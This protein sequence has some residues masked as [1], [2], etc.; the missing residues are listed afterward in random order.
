MLP[1]DFLGRSAELKELED[2]Y[3]LIANC[4]GPRVAILTAESGV[5]KTRLLVELYSRLVSRQDGDD[6]WPA[7]LPANDVSLPLNPEP[8]Q[9][10]WA[11]DRTSA[12]PFIWWG[13]RG[14][15]PQRRNSTWSDGGAVNSAAIALLPHLYFLEHTRVAN[16]VKWD[17]VDLSVDGALEA[18]GLFADSIPGV[19]LL[20]SLALNR[21]KRWKQA[22]ELLQLQAARSNIHVASELRALR[23]DEQLLDG[24]KALLTSGDTASS[25]SKGVPVVVCIDD[26]HWLDPIS[27]R[28][29]AKLLEAALQANW[30]LL[31]IFTA[32][33][34]PWHAALE[35]AVT[36]EWEELRAAL[37]TLR[38]MS[39]ADQRALEP[40]DCVDQIIRDVYLGLHVDQR[41]MIADKVGADLYRL[42][43][44]LRSLSENNRRFVDRDV[45]KELN[46]EGL[47][48]LR[49]LKRGR[50]EIVRDRFEQLPPEV[51]EF[52]GL[53]SL[54]G[55]ELPE[56][57]GL[58]V[59]GALA[60]SGWPDIG[61]Y[62]A[63]QLLERA[64][65]THFLLVRT[66][67]NVLGFAD[68]AMAEAA[69]ERILTSSEDV[70]KVRLQARV[71][72]ASWMCSAKFET[73]GWTEL[74]VFL[75]TAAWAVHHE[76][77]DGSTDRSLCRTIATSIVTM[78][79]IARMPVPREL[80]DQA[81]PDS[82][83][84]ALETTAFRS[85]LP[86]RWQ[87]K[88]LMRH[89]SDLG[90]RARESTMTYLELRDAA[91][92]NLS[93]AVDALLAKP[94]W[95]LVEAASL[96]AVAG[97]AMAWS[98]I[99][100]FQAADDWQKTLNQLPPDA[101]PP[102]SHAL[103]SEISRLT[104]GDSLTRTLRICLLAQRVDAERDRV[105]D[106]VLPVVNE[107]IALAA[108]GQFLNQ[109]AQLILQGPLA[110]ALLAWPSYGAR[111]D[112]T[113][114][115]ANA[116]V[117][118]FDGCELSTLGSFQLASLALCVPRA[119]A[120]RG[121]LA[122]RYE[123]VMNI[124]MEL[125]RRGMGAV[126]QDWTW[127]GHEAVLLES[128]HIR[129]DG[130]QLPT[131]SLSVDATWSS[132]T[133][134]LQ[135]ICAEEVHLREVDL[136]N[137]C[138]SCLHPLSRLLLEL[139]DIPPSAFSA[140]VLR[141]SALSYSARRPLTI[142]AAKAWMYE[143]QSALD[144]LGSRGAPTNV[145][146][147][148]NLLAATL[149]YSREYQGLFKDWMRDQ[150]VAKLVGRVIR[151]QVPHPNRPRVLTS[152]LSPIA[153]CVEQ[154]PEADRSEVLKSA[155]MV[156][157]FTTMEWEDQPGEQLNALLTDLRDARNSLEGGGKWHTDH[158]PVIR[159]L[160]AKYA[161]VSGSVDGSCG[162]RGAH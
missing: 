41:R 80:L 161:A 52:I 97:V 143:A 129:E 159:R 62:D 119:M 59:I 63:Q 43:E 49:K 111:L 152:C 135:R 9:F 46:S 14:V 90:F 79:Q 114:L 4:H 75:K 22:K 126:V 121:T 20:K 86:A 28:F 151:D 25:D 132:V 138:I 36:P 88:W 47:D 32:W 89:A 100:Q 30:P 133:R 34:E 55:P 113:A 120:W 94:S 146:L 56:A 92:K 27:V 71:V 18:V 103:E 57:M 104:Q 153:D 60:D 82:D 149:L 150:K 93:C 105:D 7:H 118:A 147:A 115:V 69:A 72:V 81:S 45:R 110:Q 12:A 96:S 54:M 11:E 160:I 29:L 50:G 83:T 102:I 66:T 99:N 106:F 108:G 15:D 8:A 40:S 144:R 131:S 162:F 156:L 13:L 3:E 61:G 134:K 21:W 31:L 98:A 155:L 148:I 37:S 42:R 84:D 130:V 70:A 68:D 142:A 51:R 123:L 137:L 112:H 73:L 128:G 77:V 2:T 125:I 127:T 157:T 109:S 10:N 24:L 35:G 154:F 140:Y 116:I 19:G 101:M 38:N 122:D 5:G 58:E 1:R 158:R 141:T 124:N 48:W 23:L 53:W 64:M 67:T 91:I 78:L 17:L 95:D 65:T 74:P 44:L 85:Q 39:R 87:A 139:D 26:A 16:G 117:Q 145:S 76:P 107:L 6:Y 33:P 136:I